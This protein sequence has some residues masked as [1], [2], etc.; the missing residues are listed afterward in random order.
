[1]K[2]NVHITDQAIFVF[3][4]LLPHLTEIDLSGSTEVT[5]EGFCALS[6]MTGLETLKLR[7]TYLKD[8]G[9]RALSALKHLEVLHLGCTWITDS[10][11]TALLSL[12]SL[13]DLDFSGCWHLTAESLAFIPKSVRTLNLQRCSNM[14]E[15]G[16]APQISKLPFDLTTLHLESSYVT[17]ETLHS[18]ASALSELKDLFLCGPPMMT[19]NQF[20]EIATCF[21]SLNVHWGPHSLPM[22]IQRMRLAQFR[23][24]R[25]LNFISHVERQRERVQQTSHNI[26]LRDLCAVAIVRIGVHGDRRLRKLRSSD[27][28]NDA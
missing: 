27:I 4:L 21:P 3:G 20:R 6:R 7:I 11:T 12:E 13:V 17:Q 5:D 23:K 18:L 28:F 10:G 14:F 26:I 15:D 16:F 24:V 22:V 1:L 2:D 19:E 25:I 9:L 8:D